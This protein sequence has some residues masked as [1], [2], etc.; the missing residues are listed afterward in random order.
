MSDNFYPNLDELTIAK[1]MAI[2]EGNPLYFD[3]PN[4]PYNHETKSFFKGTSRVHDFDTHNNS[5]LPDTD[6]VV[7]QLNG[8]IN[9]LKS[10]GDEVTRGN[11]EDSS[12]DRNTYFRIYSGLIEKIITMKEKATNIKMYEQFISVVLDIMDKEMD[13]DQRN[14]AMLRLEPLVGGLTIEQK[15]STPSDNNEETIGENNNET[16]QHEISDI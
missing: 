11:A 13:A 6:S 1:I 8:L 12:S 9:Q 14:R 4:C 10:W 5:E 16:K 7:S 15:T 3:D 2:Y